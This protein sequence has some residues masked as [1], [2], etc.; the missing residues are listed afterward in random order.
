MITII[1]IIVVVI[2]V[3]I[4]IIRLKLIMFL[5]SCHM[6]VIVDWIFCLFH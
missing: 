3:V 5:E 1:N 6:A 2:I 4:V